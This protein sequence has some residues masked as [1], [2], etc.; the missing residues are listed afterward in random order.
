MCVIPHVTKIALPFL[1][2]AVNIYCGNWIGKSASRTHAQNAMDAVVVFL[3]S[4][5]SSFF[6]QFVNFFQPLPLR[7]TIS[8]K[9][10]SMETNK[11]YLNMVH[12]GKQTT[13]SLALQRYIY[14]CLDE[15]E[16]FTRVHDVVCVFVQITQMVSDRGSF[17][18]CNATKMLKCENG[19]YSTSTAN[20]WL[21]AL[22]YPEWV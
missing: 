15:I 17:A 13:K 2:S 16:L 21:G 20:C 4:F 8:Y 22:N 14:V 19:C 6:L 11:I 9:L 12:W 5:F 3:F 7:Q 10:S 18:L 1:I